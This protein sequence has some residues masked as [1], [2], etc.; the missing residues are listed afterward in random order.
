MT[1][2]GR[3][4]LR[5]NLGGVASGQMRSG[6]AAYRHFGTAGLFVA[7]LV[8]L[9]CQAQSWP[10]VKEGTGP[11]APIIVLNSSI[12]HS[13]L[14]EHGQL[15][16]TFE[17]RMT[18]LATP[19]SAPAQ[20][21]T[22]AGTVK[23]TLIYTSFHQFVR[24]LAESRLPHS[25][26]AVLYDI[27]KWPATPRYEQQ[28]P[29]V[30]MRRFSALARAHGLLPIL[31]PARDLT[32]VTGGSCL[33]RGSENLS[34]AYIRCGLATADQG[35]AALVVQ[36]QAEEFNPAA[37]RRFLSMVARQ[38]RAANPRIA[39]LAQLATAPLG[40]AASVP[41]LVAAARSV[42]GLVQGYSLTA[43]NVDK[44]TTAGLLWAFGR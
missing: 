16:G 29:L 1:S 43:R 38:A 24:D 5:S 40:Q 32:L 37:F 25:V 33:K 34:E 21:P 44:E 13:V 3:R 20:V 4:R 9:G 39:V 23:N 26:H 10:P 18:F 15:A 19:A 31:A 14:A 35:A 22:L 36:S 8:L 41:Q 17:D 6:R 12:L 42:H 28:Q 2:P 27:E 7:M 11:P 30:Y